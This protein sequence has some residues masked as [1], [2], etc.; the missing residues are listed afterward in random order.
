MLRKTENCKVCNSDGC[1][2]CKSGYDLVRNG[3]QVTCKK[4]NIDKYC[5]SCDT[6]D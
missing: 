3:G 1:L 4:C 2:E 5:Q 6:Y